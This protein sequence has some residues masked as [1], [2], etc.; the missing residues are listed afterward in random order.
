MGE[1][2]MNKQRVITGFLVTLAVLAVP[3]CALTTTQ[4]K[5]AAPLGIYSAVV[6]PAGE[7]AVYVLADGNWKEAG[8]LNRQLSRC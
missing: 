2:K 5:Q 6:S 8:R 4:T 1:M 3:L 7:Y